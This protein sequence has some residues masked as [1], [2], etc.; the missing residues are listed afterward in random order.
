MKHLLHRRDSEALIEGD[1]IDDDSGLEDVEAFLT[2]MRSEFAATPAPAPRPTLA[3]TLD[4]RRELRPKSGPAPKP[5]FPKPRPRTRWGLRPVAAVFATGAVLFGGLAGA[6]ALP[7][8]IQRATASVGSHVGLHLPGLTEATPAGRNDGQ[9]RTGGPSSTSPST[10][11]E[12]SSDPSATTPS[13]APSSSSLPVTPVA[14]M[15]PTVPGAGLLPPT[16]D[17]TVPFIPQTNLPIPPTLAQLLDEL[18]HPKPPP[19]LFP[20]QPTP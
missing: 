15:V 6:G 13:T 3:A 12:K 20:P 1:P 19:S 18:T 4:G 14:P 8:P 9:P 2:T 17:P 10:Q 7:G 11:A 16:T 5:T